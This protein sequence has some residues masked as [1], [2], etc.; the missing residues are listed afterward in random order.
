MGDVNHVGDLIA[1]IR[2]A[3]DED[4][5]A[6]KAATDGP[7]TIEG[8]SI[9]GAGRAYS[10]GREGEV[11]VVKHTWPQ[12]AAHITRHDPARVLRGVAAKRAIVA[13][14]ELAISEQQ[15][16]DARYADAE[17]ATPFLSP[18]ANVAF[19]TLRSLAAEYDA[20]PGYPQ[21]RKP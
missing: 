13:D 5:A 16:F 14:C 19:R 1:A 12:E 8:M 15:E 10:G 6:A 2:A 11:L 21:E 20:H 18:A 4:E 17:R 3:L 7:W 9:R